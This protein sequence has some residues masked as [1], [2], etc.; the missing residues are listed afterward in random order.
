MGRFRTA[1]P[2][3]ERAAALLIVLAMV[4]LLTGLSVA[5]LSRTTS[6]RQV[7]QSSFHQSKVD[8]LA[9]SAMDLIIGDLRMEIANGSSPTPTA[10]PTVS[11]FPTP[12]ATPFVYPLSAAANIVPVQ[13]PVISAVPNLL[14]MSI[15]NDAV[16]YP[17]VSSHGSAVNSTADPSANFRLVNRARWN[18]HYLIPRS[19]PTPATDTSPIAAF[20]PAPD[21]VI[22]TR[23]GPTAFSGWNASLADPTQTNNSYCVG[24]YAYAIYDEGGLLDATVAGYPTSSTAAQYGPKGASVFADL[25][26]LGLSG[27]GNP[28]DIDATV[29]WRN[30]FSARQS[31]N[32][33]NFNLNA[34]NYLALVLSNTNGFITV[35][36]P[37]STPNNMS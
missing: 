25:T 21:W 26:V 3:R 6:D 34:A 12:T 15:R 27:S 13:W 8:A 37:S 4:V 24:R 32:F 29:G 33:P 1:H 16:P 30:Y 7:S 10:S 36:V 31:G 14:R 11:P 17:G 23:N 18:K 2:P 20:S 35:P 9:Q 22:L 5:Y 28:N 19:S